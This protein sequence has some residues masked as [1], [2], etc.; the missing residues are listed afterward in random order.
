VLI[1]FFS[2]SGETITEPGKKEAEKKR[3]QRQR[4]KA[5]SAKPDRKR[6]E[7]ILEIGSGGSLTLTKW[8]A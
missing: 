8:Q 3:D 4:E 2:I 1:W 5:R 7:R 6:E